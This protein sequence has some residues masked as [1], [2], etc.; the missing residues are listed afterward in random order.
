[1]TIFNS[2]V[3]LPEG[4]CLTESDLFLGLAV[5]AMTAMT[6]AQGDELPVISW[7][8]DHGGFVQVSLQ[9][10]TIETLKHLKTGVVE[11]VPW[12]F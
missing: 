11:K 4:K 6:F 12:K 3:K 5:P 7:S 1:M 10:T 2:Y 9:D 8:M